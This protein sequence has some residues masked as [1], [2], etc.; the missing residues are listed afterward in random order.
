[1][2]AAAFLSSF[3]IFAFP[4]ALAAFTALVEEFFRVW[5]FLQECLAVVLLLLL[6]GKPL[7]LH[8]LPEGSFCRLLGLSELFCGFSKLL[9][10]GLFFG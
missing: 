4:A 5:I 8:L 1:M 2:F 7:C 10:F 6:E 9:P 3:A